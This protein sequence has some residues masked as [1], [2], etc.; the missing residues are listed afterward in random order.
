M[1]G[2]CGIGHLLHYRDVLHGLALG[3][4]PEADRL[5]WRQSGDGST[6]FARRLSPKAAMELGNGCGGNQVVDMPTS[7]ALVLPSREAENGQMTEAD[8][9]RYGQ[10]A[11]QP[12]VSRGEELFLHAATTGH[13]KLVEVPGKGAHASPPRP[14][15]R[16]TE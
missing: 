6:R 11:I 9:D 12:V 15:D 3:G 14:D 1:K 2:D 10:A 7:K 4:P 8:P 5:P 16:I 13:L